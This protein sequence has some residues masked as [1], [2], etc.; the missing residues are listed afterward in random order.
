M[1]SIPVMG[2][3]SL[4]ISAKSF[5]SPFLSALDASFLASGPVGGSVIELQPIYNNDN[6][7][8]S[9]R[10]IDNFFSISFLLL[11]PATERHKGAMAL[12]RQKAP[13][14]KRG[15]PKAARH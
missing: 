5:S 6:T 7:N 2:L 8:S 3:Q 1:V 15:S 12:R 4:I 13:R 11:I 10:A 14:Q 9:P